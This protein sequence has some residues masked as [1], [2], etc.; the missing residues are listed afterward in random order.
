MFDLDE[1]VKRKIRLPARKLRTTL[2]SMA[3]N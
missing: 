3:R 1:E 2:Q